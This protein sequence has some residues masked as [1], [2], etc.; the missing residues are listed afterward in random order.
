MT[1]CA[2]LEAW[3]LASVVLAAPSAAQAPAAVGAFRD[4]PML[5]G[6]LEIEL[7]LNAAPRHLRDGAMVLVLESTGEVKAREGRGTQCENIDRDLDPQ[8]TL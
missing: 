8:S 4:H 7:A 3:A 6:D 2:R 5:P 1:I